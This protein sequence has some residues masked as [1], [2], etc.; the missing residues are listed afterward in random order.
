M[1]DCRDLEGLLEDFA[2]G[3]ID[4]GGRVRIE[5]HLEG[6]S[7]CRE[8]LRQT[9]E[10]RRAAAALAPSIPPRRDLWPAIAS[11]LEGATVVPLRRRAVRWL[12]A[13][14]AVAAAAAVALVV[15]PRERQAAPVS[16]RGHEASGARLAVSAAEPALGG[17]EDLDRAAAELRR[18]LEATRSRLDPDTRRVIDENLA[19]IDQAIANVRRALDRD[20]DNRALAVLLTA[21]CQRRIEFLRIATEASQRT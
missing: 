21:T 6:C 5:A 7:S 8:R 17:C 2:D 3:D 1:T 11:R 14:A 20:P 19:I 4:D 18:V 10:L 9:L 12:G 13:V 16:G 15:L